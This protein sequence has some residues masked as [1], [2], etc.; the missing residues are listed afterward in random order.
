MVE[1]KLTAQERKHLHYLRERLSRARVFLLEKSD[2]FPLE[3]RLERALGEGFSAT[4][5]DLF[6][7]AHADLRNEWE[8]IREEG[9]DLDGY[10]VTLDR[11]SEEELETFEARIFAFIERYLA[12]TETAA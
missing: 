8:A 12:A 7:E 1:D 11:M 4:L 10:R 9:T 3:V 2:K 6:A 5:T